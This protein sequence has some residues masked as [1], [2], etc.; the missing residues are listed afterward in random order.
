CFLEG[1]RAE[2][3][4]M[5]CVVKV[6]GHARLMPACATRAE[7]GMVVE[8]ETD[9]VKAARR[10]ALD[11]LL[12]EHVGDCEAPCRRACP[13]HVNIPRM[14]RQI[15]EGEHRE[16]LITEKRDIALPAVLGRICPAPCEKACRR[17]PYDAP[18]AI[19]LL[20]RWAA[21]SDLA[22]GAPWLPDCKPASGKKIAIVGAGPAGLSAAYYLLQDGHA[23]RIFDD[24]EAPGGMLTY[25]V[26]ATQLP[27]EV[28]AAEVDIIRRL[29]AEFQ[30]KTAVGRDVPFGE[31]EASFDAVALTVGALDAA[32]AEGFGVAMAERG[33]RV[34][35]GSFLTSRARVFAGGD[36]LQTVRMAVRAVSH[37]KAIALA[38]GQLLR[39]EAVTGPAHR[40]DCRIGR[41]KDGEMAEFLTEADP[42]P[43]QAPAEKGH[44]LSEDQAIFE[45]R[46]CL[47]C[48]C[49][50]ADACRLRDQ[51]DACGASQQRYPALGRRAAGAGPAGEVDRAPVRRLLDHAEVACEPGKCIKC[52]LCVQVT[53]RSGEKLGLGF[54]GRG[55]D[56]QIGV[57]V[58]E[59]LVRA[60]EKDPLRC[61]EVCPT[62]ALAKRRGE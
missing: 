47:R 55:Y 33:I 26:P 49:R 15:A 43:R 35:P 18:V 16:A 3:S 5:V 2:T 62:G 45:A 42:G 31:I 21:D 48:D 24:H 27:R 59:S 54:T 36:A 17:A 39:G 7:D 10:A 38:A 61:I 6:Q 28:L 57:P 34:A 50:K 9:E 19:C 29:G 46:R 52:G 53:E 60:I 11:L 56:T 14:I 12:S 4:C 23:C 30:M 22:P 20:R 41:L 44:G 32:R 1:W 25:G 13:A 58:N 40:F 37:G 8:S 51:A